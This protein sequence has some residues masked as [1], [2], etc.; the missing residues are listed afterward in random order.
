[1]T[2]PS[3]P[4][5][6]IGDAERDEAAGYLRDHLAAGRLD[7]AEFDDRVTQAL[8]AKTANDLALLFGDLPAPKPSDAGSA[9]LPS[10]TVAT[11]AG[12]TRASQSLVPTK[13]SPAL[14]I[15]ATAAWPITLM[16][17]FATDW[18]YWWL[19]FIPILVSSLAGQRY[20]GH[21]PGPPA[22]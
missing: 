20:H 19:I 17:L 10:S 5:P 8:R 22:H 3:L 14:T 1:M 12:A 18:Q 11:G 21:R 16:V 13:P 6:R 2:E 4:S 15:A 7:P 9:G